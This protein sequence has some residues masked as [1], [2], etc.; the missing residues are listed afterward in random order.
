MLKLHYIL[1]KLVKVCV[2]TDSTALQKS[3]TQSNDI[4]A[5]ANNYRLVTKK[6]KTDEPKEITQKYYS[7]TV[8]KN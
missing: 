3:A 8:L 7:K 4:M 2:T 6:P 1:L 5:T